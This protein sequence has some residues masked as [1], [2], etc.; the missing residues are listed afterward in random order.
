MKV[1]AERIDNHKL[2]LEMEV[3][4][5]EVAKA[6]DKAYQKLANRVNIPGFRKGK[7]PRKVLEMRIGKEALL[8]EAFD[9][10]APQ[11]Y[12]KALEEQQVEPVTQPEIEVVTFAEDQPLTFKA[13]IIAKPSIELGEYKGLTVEKPSATVSDEEVTKQLEAMRDRQAKMVVAE[14]AALGSGDFAIIDFEGFVDGQPFSGGEAKGYPLEVGSGSFIPGFEEQLIGAKAGDD[15]EVKVT[16]PAD[17]FVAELA[18]KEADFKVKVHDIKRKELPQLDD[19][20]AKDVSDFDTLEAL[21]ADIKN[22]LEQAA[23]E[24]AERDFRNNAVK[25]AV[26]NA[27]VDIPDVMVDQKVAQ[28]MQDFQMN[29]ESRGMKFEDYL[30]YSGMDVSKLKES[31][32]EPALANVK[33]DLLLE[34]VAKA[35]K[36]EVAPADMEMEVAVMAQNYGANPKDVWEIIR[37]EGR[38][39]GLMESVMRRKAAQFIIDNTVQA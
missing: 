20:F 5:A 9:I 26:D 37:K 35:E 22:K 25:A 8:D 4:Q 6:V 16:F 13:T 11:A 23:M 15:R 14:G 3:P 24:K 36:I 19:D 21:T 1:T 39:M 32:R 28:M 33:T 27:T 10:L 29:L 30:Q 18:G 12:N 34:A 17:Y 31:Y 2:V 38:I 7:V